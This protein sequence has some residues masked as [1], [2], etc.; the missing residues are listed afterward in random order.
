MQMQ[1]ILI[2]YCGP[3]TGCISEINN[4][5]VGNAKDSDVVLLLYNM[6]EYSNNY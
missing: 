6:L 3:F 2:R 4:E 5:R 1:I